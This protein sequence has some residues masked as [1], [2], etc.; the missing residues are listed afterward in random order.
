VARAILDLKLA[1]KHYRAGLDEDHARCIARV[2]ER[3][4]GRTLSALERRAI[5][6]T[7][8]WIPGCR[9]LLRDIGTEW[10]IRQVNGTVGW[11]K[12]RRRHARLSPRRIRDEE[13]GMPPR[14]SG[15]DPPGQ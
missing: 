11:W 2:R 7:A 14:S 3:L 8:I 9:P 12:N 10:M 13:L 1:R 15:G 5:T 4:S 6:R